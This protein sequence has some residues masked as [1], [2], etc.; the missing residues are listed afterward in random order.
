MA[1]VF[2]KL[3]TNQAGTNLGLEENIWQ[4]QSSGG[5]RDA[6]STITFNTDG[7]VTFAGSGVTNVINTS[8]A[9]NWNTNGGTHISYELGVALEDGGFTTIS[10]DNGTATVTGS[11]ANSSFLGE[12]RHSLAS[13]FVLSAVST[14]PIGGL[15]TI[16]TSDVTIKVS[17]WDAASGGRRR[18]YG[19]YRA[20]ALAG[21]GL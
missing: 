15:P 5:S 13:N 11:L 21:S 9:T 4:D 10:A 1:T 6:T 20:V 17:I 19:I 16:Y 2:T 12:N 8:P 7:T 18:A 14:W 3:N